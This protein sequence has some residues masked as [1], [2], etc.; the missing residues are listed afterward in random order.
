MRIVN[1]LSVALV[2]VR[3]L[4]YAVPELVMAFSDTLPS[5]CSH[6]IAC[7]PRLARCVMVDERALKA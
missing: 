4:V 1:C 2:C 5:R 3:P 6:F 7:H